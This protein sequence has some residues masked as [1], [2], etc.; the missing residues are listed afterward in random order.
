MERVVKEV[1]VSLDEEFFVQVIRQV[2]RNYAGE[3]IAVLEMGMKFV[4]PL[5]VKAGN[6]VKISWNGEH[7]GTMH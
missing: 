6:R 7:L 2:F 5:S 3:N 4:V 1:G